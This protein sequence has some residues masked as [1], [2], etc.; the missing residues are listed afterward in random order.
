VPSFAQVFQR[1]RNVANDGCE[2]ADLSARDWLFRV[3]EV[4]VVRYADD[5]VLGLQYPAEADRFLEDFRARLG[6]FRLELHR[7]KT[8]RIEFG[9][10]AELN[11]NSRGEGKPETFDFPGFTP[12]SGRT[13]K[14]T[15]P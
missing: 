7:E 5:T 6:K 4:I 10:Y 12:I 13:R 3:R 1:F 11:R 14:G 15:L 2:V 8:R 9:R